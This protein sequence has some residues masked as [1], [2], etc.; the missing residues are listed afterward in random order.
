MTHIPKKP[1]QAA[2]SYQEIAVAAICLS[3]RDS[4]YHVPL[5]GYM[6]IKEMTVLS[7]CSLKIKSE[8][9]FSQD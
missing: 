1:W 8:I 6:S 4:M 7:L 9:Q 3:Q 5:Q 2:L